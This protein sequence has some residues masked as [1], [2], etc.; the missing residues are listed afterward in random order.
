MQ[1]PASHVSFTIHRP[2]ELAWGL[3]CSFVYVSF[4][5]TIKK[6]VREATRDTGADLS[7][8]R[9]SS[10]ISHTDTVRFR[11]PV[12]GTTPPPAPGR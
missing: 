6:Y 9:V 2:Q 4:S 11:Y 10:I 3:K 1:L 5:K 7:S 12:L 8:N